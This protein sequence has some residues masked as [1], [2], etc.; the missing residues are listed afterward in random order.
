LRKDPHQIED[1][2]LPFMLGEGK[3][4]IWWE[5]FLDLVRAVN[6]HPKI[7][8]TYKYNKLERHEIYFIFFK[9]FF[10]FIFLRSSRCWNRMNELAK[11]DKSDS[12]VEMTS[13]AIVAKNEWR[14]VR[15]SSTNSALA[16]SNFPEKYW[17]IRNTHNRIRPITRAINTI[18]NRCLSC[19][20]RP[21]ADNDI[22]ADPLF[23]SNGDRNIVELKFTT[24][25]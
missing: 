23:A 15:R 25:M 16:N 6:C 22:T 24:R 14:S 13:W 5:S 19:P 8:N 9:S 20:K 3:S 11:W 17:F 1:F 4:S 2:P 7:I 10:K 12:T 18:R 21:C